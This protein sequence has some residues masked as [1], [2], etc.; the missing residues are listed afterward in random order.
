ML[1]NLMFC[2]K[3]ICSPSSYFSTEKSCIQKIFGHFIFVNKFAKFYSHTKL[4]SENN[5]KISSIHRINYHPKLIL[6]GKR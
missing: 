3:T 1:P 5:L 6:S 2:K 4:N